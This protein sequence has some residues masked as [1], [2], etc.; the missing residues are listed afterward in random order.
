M[1]ETLK[2]EEERKNYIKILNKIAQDHYGKGFHE[3]CFD[4][5]E[6]VKQLYLVGVK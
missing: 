6:I 2:T 1:A 5:Q 3:V 4:R